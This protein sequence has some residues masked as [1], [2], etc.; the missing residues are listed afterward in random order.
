[1]GSCAPGKVPA[2][3]KG[4]Q[5]CQMTQ[6]QLCCPSTHIF[7]LNVVITNQT[8]TYVNLPKLSLNITM[9]GTKFYQMFCS[10]YLS[11]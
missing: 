1:M 3:V 7:L 4:S 9:R 5:P 8:S 11:N 2:G 10:A 6:H